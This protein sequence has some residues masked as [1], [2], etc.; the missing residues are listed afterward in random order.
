MARH[1]DAYKI[2]VKAADIA[3]DRDHTRD[4][5]NNGEEDEYK[6]ADGN[7]NFIANYTKGFRHHP[8][9]DRDAGE[10]INEDYRKLLDAIDSE[11][12]QD[13]EN[14]Q[15]GPFVPPRKLTSP[16]AG[17][18]FDLEGP[19]AQDLSIREAPK[20]KDAEAAAEMAELYWMA[21]CRDV[22]FGTFD[23]D[24]TIG[25][26]VADLSSNY[27][28]FPVSPI[29]GPAV[30]V[31]RDTIFRGMT[32]GDFKGPYISQFLYLPIPWGSQILR[33]VQRTVKP[34]DYLK[35][36]DSWLRAQDGEVIPATPPDY[37]LGDEMNVRPILTPRDLAHYVHVDALYQAYLGAC[38]I[39]LG[40]NYK[41]DEK[42]P[43]QDSETQD[44]FAIFGGPHILS[45]VTEVATR[46]LK[47]VWYT[48]WGVHRRLRT[49]AL[50]G[51]NS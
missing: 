25:E 17:F 13:F 30:N 39:L 12:P 5:S 40:G 46:A 43:Y 9:S 36:Y 21:L 19:D 33:Q 16:Q 49:E 51:P 14:L 28:K 48:K 8:K 47:A 7:R 45:L 31:T 38:L 3:R 44:G 34:Q 42:L 18:A 24:S 4:H 29:P 15:L 6:D 41:F 27:N 32:E 50:G 1:D 20:I 2:R 10:V 22:P 35:D 26:A 37:F 11:K 23:V